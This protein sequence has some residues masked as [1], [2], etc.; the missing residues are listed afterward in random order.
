MGKT[1]KVVF[2]LGAGF[3]SGAYFGRNIIPKTTKPAITRSTDTEIEEE[4]EDNKQE[5]NLM[6]NLALK[7]IDGNPEYHDMVVDYIIDFK[8]KNNLPF[9]KETIDNLANLVKKEV[10]AYPIQMKDYVLNISKIGLNSDY[11]VEIW[12][13][14]T[15]EEKSEL[16]NNVV[17]YKTKELLD[18][19]RDITKDTYK[20]IME[21]IED[22]KKGD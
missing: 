14:L 13:Q 12:Q 20:K 1:L 18:E 11:R 16:I 4:V 5:K 10:E 22:T 15:E 3:L 21:F 8:K 9:S 19:T 7:Y 2:L 6:L 17:G